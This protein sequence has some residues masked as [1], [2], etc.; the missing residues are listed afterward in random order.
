MSVGATNGRGDRGA[1]GPT[2]PASRLERAIGKAPA[3][4]TVDDL[5]ALFLQERLQLVSLMHVGGDGWLKTLDFVPRDLQHLRDVLEGGER[6]D[7][8]SLF[9]GMGIRTESSDILLRPRPA[10]A[11]IDPFAHRPT[12]VVMC[13]HA[14]RDGRPLPESP[15]TIV[16]AAFERVR[17]EA[18]VTLRALGEVELFLGK[19]SAEV[20]A[21]G[22]ADRGYHAASP[23]VYGE[24]LRREALVLLAEMGI[25]VKYGHSEVGYVEA[26]E[27]AGANA[28]VGRIF[29]QHEIEL[30]L[31]PLP[32]A[33]DAV[34]LAQ[35]VLRNLAHRHDMVASFEP[36]VVP[37]H[38]GSG[39]H[40]H[41]S[42][43][44]DGVPVG[45]RRPDGRLHDPARWLIGGLV[46]V[47][48]ALM[49]FGNRVEGSFVRLNQGKE[50]PNTVVWGDCDRKALVRLPLVPTRASGAAIAAPTVEFRLPDGSTHPHLLLAGIAQALVLG[51]ETPDLD[52][53]LEATRSGGAGGASVP[54]TFA[55]VRDALG[56]YE[57]VLAAGGVFPP[58]LLQAAVQ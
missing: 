48:G 30:A 56:R 25:P 50:A 51:K 16:R 41:M 34:V 26:T 11:F 55:E 20:D 15:D 49:A 17:A 9:R 44:V 52:A 47:G 57:A 36:I 19:R 3:T 12:L 35:W 1:T 28:D 37:G 22:A 32:E 43:E 31:S 6:A 46:Q 13:G 2:L 5:I 7:G 39:M 10:S 21:Y 8:S 4:W 14:G 53:L 40:F 33:A 45:G 58:R 23:F 42:P 38:A 18:G 54:R 24:A 29:E 27:G